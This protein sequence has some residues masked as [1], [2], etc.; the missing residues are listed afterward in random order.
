MA[1]VSSGSALVSRGTA[2]ARCGR[3]GGVRARRAGAATLRAA[4]PSVER[5]P[6]EVITEGPIFRRSGLRLDEGDVNWEEWYK[7][8]GVLARELGKEATVERIHKL[9]LPVYFWLRKQV[10]IKRAEKKSAVVIGLSCPQGGGKTTITTFLRK[11][12]AL[13]G[14]SC[15]IASTDDFYLTNEE[16]RKLAKKYE[17]DHLLEYRGNPGTMDVELMVQT[18]NDLKSAKEGDIVPIPR[19]NKSAFNGRGD[20]QP[21]SQWTISEG[22]V[23]VVILEGWCVG[24]QPKETLKNPDLKNVNRYLNDFAR[25][26]NL[27]DLM[28]VVQITNLDN[29][30]TW[31]KQAEDTMKRKGKGGMSDEEL[32]DFVDRFMPAYEEY[33]PQLYKSGVS[34]S[35]EQLNIKI[36]GKRTPIE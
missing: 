14:L 34:S 5:P 22:A 35:V 27:F 13:D 21:A 26:Y 31:R 28:L 18:V 16:Q 10:R 1:F 7:L 23:D 20:R 3:V 29:I 32:R 8:A 15:A 12:F 17:S 4:L 25:V 6:V 9:Y 2:L 30:Y 24:F 19:Y 33:L 36:D 11:L